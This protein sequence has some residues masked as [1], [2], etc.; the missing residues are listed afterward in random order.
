MGE[1]FNM[2]AVTCRSYGAK[3]ICLLNGYRHI[4]PTGFSFF[5]EVTHLLFT[6]E[7]RK[8]EI[9]KACFYGI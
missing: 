7:T 2:L 5:I 9:K 3:M 1:P 6:A 8:N 4:T